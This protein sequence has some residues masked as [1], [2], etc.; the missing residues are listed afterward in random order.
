[1][2]SFDVSQN[3][4]CV[5]L[6]VVITLKSSAKEVVITEQYHVSVFTFSLEALQL[7]AMMNMVGGKGSDPSMGVKGLGFPLWSYHR[8][9][10]V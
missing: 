10:Y 3:A 1:M 7:N 9:R 2:E 6:L 8:S 4:L 5:R